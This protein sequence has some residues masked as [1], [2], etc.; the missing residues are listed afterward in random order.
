MSP[1]GAGYIGSHTTYELLNEGYNVI[2]ADNLSKGTKA[3]VDQRAHFYQID[4]TDERDLSDLL[5]NENVDALL[6]CA[7]SI[8]VSESIE[9]PSNYYSDNVSG[10]NAVLKTI[11]D[12]N[13]NKII[14]SST[15]SVYG[16]NCSNVKATEDTLVDPINPYAET[17]YAG[18]RLLHW[19]ASR[20][21]WKYI[22][23]RY[24]NVA[25]AMPNKS[26]GLRVKHP[27]H[28]I[29]NINKA[30]LRKLDCVK[31]FGT[32]YPT[33]DGTCIRDYIHVLDLAKA[34]VLGFNYLFNHGESNLFNLGTEC[35]YS[36]LQ[37]ISRASEVT[38]LDVPYKLVGRR[39]GDPASV[40]AN[41]DKAKNILGWVPQYNLNDI[42]L[43][44]F[45]WR[46]TEKF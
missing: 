7:G 11:S 45:E 1:G 10:M 44:D 22:V 36:V 9:N 25:G 19:M 18:E 2:V 27:T 31:V 43:S 34:H 3:A 29:P 46:K 6:H 35:G 37:I 21:G 14:F 12:F 24:F 39:Q 28:I 15:A 32:D 8:V 5:E 41:A 20:Y 13:I 26:N 42:I 17:K 33:I 4:V 23:F 38:G 40:L 16:N 30:I